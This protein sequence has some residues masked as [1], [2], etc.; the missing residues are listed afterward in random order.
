MSSQ[1]R[2]RVQRAEVGGQGSIGM[3][4]EAADASQEAGDAV[5]KELPQARALMREASSLSY[6]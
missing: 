3:L 1:M 6:Q 5:F 2:W 4:Q